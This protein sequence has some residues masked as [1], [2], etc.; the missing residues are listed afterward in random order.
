MEGL[1]VAYSTSKFIVRTELWGCFLTSDFPS[2]LLN[3]REA[4]VFGELLKEYAAAATV[5]QM[6]RKVIAAVV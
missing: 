5:P 2:G 4:Q 1:R 6:L 3:L